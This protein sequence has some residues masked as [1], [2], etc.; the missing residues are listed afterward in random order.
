MK[1][2]FKV[3]LLPTPTA[4]EIRQHNPQ[5]G[6]HPLSSRHPYA[7]SIY[8]RTSCHRIRSMSLFPIL[9][10]FIGIIVFVSS[11]FVRQNEEAN[12]RLFV[13]LLGVGGLCIVIWLVWSG[14]VIGSGL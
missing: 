8:T 7:A 9:F 11:M 3:S 12:P 6:R 1:I 10:L 13:A 14:V 4:L 2:H 5:F